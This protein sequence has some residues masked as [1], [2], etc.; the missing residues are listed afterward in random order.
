MSAAIAPVANSDIAAASPTTTRFMTLSPS[1][2]LDRKI[3]VGLRECCY[4]P[5]TS[6]N[7]QRRSDC[8]QKCRQNEHRFDSKG[9]FVRRGASGRI[10]DAL[11]NLPLLIGRQRPF[12]VKNRRRHGG[13]A[14]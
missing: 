5:A 10:S 13:G 2:N 9:I 4:A 8:R 11:P 6:G 12:G 7:K 3:S 14:S 1:K